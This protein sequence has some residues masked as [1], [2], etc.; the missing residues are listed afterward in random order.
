MSEEWRPVTGYEGL[1]EVSS[2]GQVKRVGK[3]RGTR[4]GILSPGKGHHLSVTLTKGGVQKRFLIHRLVA[5][6]FIPNPKG[7]PWVLHWDDN[8]SNN[9]VAN[10]RWGTPKQNSGDSK[11]NNRRG[12]RESCPRG[13]R[14]TPENLVKYAFSKRGVKVCKACS[15]ATDYARARGLEFDPSV[16]DRKYLDVLEGIRRNK[17]E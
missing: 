5:Q 10:L 17:W 4:T 6:A 8:P 3:G 11:R 2:W 15:R 7:D 16:A 14:Y 1:Y 12:V 13:H 9:K